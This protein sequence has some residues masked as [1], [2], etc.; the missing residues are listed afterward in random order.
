MPDVELLG[1]FLFLDKIN[2]LDEE[3]GFYPLL[4]SSEQWYEDVMFGTGTSLSFDQI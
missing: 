2:E 4:L 3:K 1:K